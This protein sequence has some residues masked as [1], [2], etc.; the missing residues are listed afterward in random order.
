MKLQKFSYVFSM[1]MTVDV[2]FSS[3]QSAFFESLF[4][5]LFESRLEYVALYNAASWVDIY[6]SFL[7]HKFKSFS[8]S[9]TLTDET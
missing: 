2:S 7:T 9:T 1:I 4:E 8:E 3:S 5:S 6:L